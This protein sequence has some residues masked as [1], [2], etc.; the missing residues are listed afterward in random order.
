VERLLRATLVALQLTAIGWFSPG[1]GLPLDDAW[2]HQ[3]VA[4]T[5]AETGTLGYAPGQHGAAATS[6]LWA[7]LLA[8]NF[9]IAHLD[10]S[11]W[12]L[13]LNGAAALASGQ[14]LFTLLVRACSI[15]NEIEWTVT[16]FVVAAL[17]SVSPN[18]LWFTCS[19][20]EAMPFVA[21]SLGAITAATDP[22]ARADTRHALVAGFAAGGLALLRPEAIPLGALLTTWMFVR[23]KSPRRAILVALPWAAMV[24][25]YAGS[26]ILKTGHVLPS[27]LAGRRWLWF[28][29]SVGLSRSD[30]AL[31]FLDL[32]GTRLGSYT[33]DTSLAVTWI[34]TGIGAYGALRL[35]RAPAN[36]SKNE[37]TSHASHAP[38]T[39]RTSDRAGVQLLFAWA[40]F[41]AS[42]YALLLPTP[43]H[44]GRYQ[45]FTPLLFSACVP[46]GATFLLRELVQIAGAPNIRFVWFAAFG[47]LPWIPL[48]MP[49][50]KSLRHANALA[51]AHIHATEIGAGKFVSQLPEGKIA[52]FDIGGIGWA[53]TR[54]IL[55][56]GG[57]SD[58]K[59][60]TALE[61]GRVSTFL[62]SNQVRWM[63]LPEAAEPV[64]PVF[65]D[66]RSR[67]RLRDNP[68]IE[69]EPIRVFE[70][71]LDKWGPAI[72]ATWNA[73]PKQ[74][75]YEVRYTSRPGPRTVAT[76]DPNARKAIADPA[77]LVSRVDR[78]VA[79]HMLAVLAAWGMEVDVRVTDEAASPPTAT[80]GA[81]WAGSRASSARGSESASLASSAPPDRALAVATGDADPK[82]T[83]PC[84][85]RLGWWGFA[86]DGCD[87]IADPSVLRAMAYEQ[88]G[89]YIDVGDL[90]GAIRAVPH[91]LAQARRRADPR[92]S[93]SLAP[94]MPPTPGGNELGSSRAGRT[95]LLLLFGVFVV[96]SLV[97]LAARR[98]LR[99]SRI[100]AIARTRLPV[101]TAVMMAM[102]GVV[103]F[104]PSIGCTRADVGGAIGGGRGAVELALDSGGNPNPH[105]R[106][107]PLLDAAAAGDAAIVSL[108]LERGANVD[109]HTPDGA[110]PL[111]VAARHGHAAAVAVLI[112]AM[113]A[114][115][116]DTIRRDPPLLEAPAGL[117][118]RTALHDAVTSGS[119][120]CVE[121]LVD[122]GADVNAV[123]SFEQTPLHLVATIDPA[124]AALIAP[125]LRRA[126]TRI[127]DARGFTPLHAAAVTDNVPVLQNLAQSE[128]SYTHSLRTPSGETALDVA[129]RYE[130]DRAA[131]QLLRSGSIFQR[132]RAWPPL[133]DAARMDSV[134]RVA[135]LLANGADVERRFNDVTALELAR[136][137]GS[138]RVE[139]LLQDRTR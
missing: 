101:S 61:E 10:A 25:L 87:S 128:S 38:D 138:K 20:M 84:A 98:N 121:A 117:R 122:A 22:R 124:R 123:D 44:G 100:V 26:N 46:L 40:I 111:H 105:G 133:H 95:G 65:D 16:S 1:R 31:D 90:G 103:A 102:V 6:Y 64:L 19:G 88:A 99:L 135:T 94:L 49:V 34:F 82:L 57:L 27:T 13:L 58:A 125:L 126:D 92:F 85:V 7:A 12:A 67:L 29:T 52:S 132:E 68:A 108:L 32:W 45:P 130:R 60:A 134:E 91:V 76:I 63:V 41:H 47:L 39:T 3:V 11:L 9:K 15:R 107:P 50:A 110:T 8:L 106:R 54:R 116:T 89:R 36:E 71:P 74:V 97:D 51:V 28:A 79:E 77:S 86:I 136:Q 4:R 70:T 131:E 112:T 33:L 53:T 35:V 14:L 83:G 2:I 48:A 56:L 137:R 129:I 37:D 139:A 17:A 59:T 93:P 80:L 96:A 114:L 30:R 42:F 113:R 62:E 55:D 115:P 73:S 78:L 21:L 23:A 18:V 75:L 72:A 69:I 43:G 66:F 120:A 127:H 119:P 109:V 81:R 5:F 104:A 24:A 118:R